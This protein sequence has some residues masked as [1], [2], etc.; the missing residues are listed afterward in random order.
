[1]SHMKLSSPK[2]EG[3]EGDDCGT[4][5][6]D[7]VIMARTPHGSVDPDFVPVGPRDVRVSLSRV[8]APP[9][10]KHNAFDPASKRQRVAS[11][12]LGPVILHQYHRIHISDDVGINA[13]LESLVPVCKSITELL[14]IRKSYVWVPQEQ[15]VAAEI[16]QGKEG[17]PAVQVPYA[18]P[19]LS[20]ALPPVLP[21]TYQLID[22]VFAL[23]CTSA[24]K[25][26]LKG[27]PIP[28]WM[29]FL[30]S[31]RKLM[32]ALTDGPTLSFSY[33]RL[34]I[35][36]AKF[37]LH[38][39]MNADLEALA[40]K[41]ISHRDFY[42]VR[43]VDNHVHHSACM[44]Q[45]HM[46]RFIKHKLKT[47]P[48]Q[49]VI[50]NEEGQILTLKGV[51]KTL[52]LSPYDLNVDVLDMHAKNTFQRFDRFNLKYNPFGQSWLREIFLK[53]SNLLRG[54]YL[55]EITQQ[56]FEDLD[57][58]KYQFAEYRLSIY[59]RSA[60]EWSNLAA[61]VV[62][63]NL[64]NSHC[65]WMIQIPR[66]FGTYRRSGVLANFAQ[67]LDNIFRP[68]FAVSIDP[69]SDP[70]LHCFLK[71]MV[72]F[73][74]VDDESVREVPARSFP[75]PQNWTLE[76]NPP[77]MYFSYYLYAN[78]LALNKLRYS[79]G[80]S[81]FRYRPHAGEAGDLDHLA[82]AFLLAHS[83]NH[84]I[85]LKKHPAAQYLFYLAQIGLSISPLSNNL[86]FLEYSKNPFPQ[87]F[88]RGLN[89]TLSTDDPL[90]I[91]VTREP[92][93]EEYSVAA[94]VW[95]LTGCDMCEIARNSVLQSGY[96]HRYKAKWLGEKYWHRS[97]EGNDLKQSNVPNIRIEF[98]NEAL[99][100][101]FLNL[102]KSQGLPPGTLSFEDLI[103]A[104]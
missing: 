3:K 70:K 102:E 56:V 54:R 64:F 52:Q 32:K 84:G 6:E 98:R 43:K 49:E 92:L 68:L 30:E 16:E 15:R 28:S 27:P 101:E 59:G 4:E 40:Q 11:P 17:R 25:E 21:Y 13:A 10:A 48:D 37:K 7:I 44:N 65:R 67:M 39:L 80:L 26:E 79:N 57:A 55:A 71:Q 81:T 86:L 34:Q 12:S 53:T 38:G 93:V 69:S 31:L 22:G 62:D 24:T 35:L 66:L 29:D 97:V 2:L 45:K 100:S 77:Y 78:I 72:G 42:N 87:F 46:L 91:H 85:V 50:R 36:D 1:M 5:A 76:E 60:G 103:D 94:Q 19:Q 73:D 8:V 18:P 41:T 63:H 20:D 51:F 88:S 96:E 99:K 90:M 95:K 82:T 83:I 61:W 9:E 104:L 75:L 23:T 47:E 58:N 89:V 33:K 14:A 74:S